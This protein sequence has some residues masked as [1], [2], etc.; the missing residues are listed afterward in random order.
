M[1]IQALQLIPA[2][3]RYSSQDLLDFVQNAMWP[4]GSAVPPEVTKLRER[5]GIDS[6]NSYLG[7]EY[8]GRES[9]L[10]N[11]S[12]GDRMGLYEQAALETIS[13][14]V[15]SEAFALAAV[16]NLVSV[17]CTGYF[18]PGLDINL[19]RQLGLSEQTERYNLGA[20]GCQGG[21]SALR[22]ASS[23]KDETVIFCFEFCSLHFQV[24]P[25]TLSNFISNAIF[26]DGASL[27]RVGRENISS[28][29]SWR[30]IAQ[31]SILLDG[32]AEMMTWRLG[33]KGFKMFLSSRIIK[34]I[35]DKL[36]GVLELFLADND[37]KL[38]QIQG[39]AIHPGGRGI[40]DAVEKALSLEAGDLAASRQ[41]LSQY[42]NMSSNT[43]FYVLDALKTKGLTLALAFGPGLS[44]ELALLESL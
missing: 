44:F 32:S 33:D 6:R 37:V 12:T 1:F 24:E 21:L 14:I 31:R 4:A 29:R 19:Q 13:N 30:L 22:L 28:Q 38:E 9:A 2:P 41:T 3:K 35:Q 42:G 43:I 36:L 5:L 34:T 23:L 40:L 26:A 11:G 8:F 15:P 7:E 27:V 18:T 17:S 25:A 20:I 10:I 39:W 16:K